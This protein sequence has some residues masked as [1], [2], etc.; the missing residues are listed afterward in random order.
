MEFRRHCSCLLLLV[1]IIIISSV[2]ITVTSLSKCLQKSRWPR[3]VWDWVM[4][5]RLVHGQGQQSTFDS[6][7]CRYCRAD[8]AVVC[9]LISETSYMNIQ[10]I[11]LSLFLWWSA[12]CDDRGSL[13]ESFDAANLRKRCLP[14][15]HFWANVLVYRLCFKSYLG[16]VCFIVMWIG[17]IFFIF[18]FTILLGTRK[19]N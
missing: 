17:I 18:L 4:K 19:L 11:F 8:K 1:V 5:F 7:F 14:T 16:L 13:E 9:K 3:S 10:K 12:L 6:L 15:S 2:I